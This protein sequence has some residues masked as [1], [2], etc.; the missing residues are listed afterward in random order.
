MDP[1]QGASNLPFLEDAPSKEPLRGSLMMT[2]ARDVVIY[3]RIRR[4]L[5]VS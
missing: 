5:P 3:G 4:G 1:Q 2:I